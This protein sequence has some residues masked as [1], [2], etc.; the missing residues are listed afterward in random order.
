MLFD[1]RLPRFPLT[2]VSDYRLLAKKRLPHQIFEFLDGGAFDEVTKRLNS[3]DFQRIL[4]RKRVLRDVSHI[5][6]KTE[7]LGHK[8]DFPVI[9]APV[10]FAGLFA[11]RGEVQAARAAYKANIPFSLSSVGICSMEEVSKAS[12]NPFW[13]ELKI[14]KDRK[15]S[16]ENLELAKNL[17]CSVLFLTVDLPIVGARYRYDR[18]R[19]VS[20]LANFW[21]I[22]SHFSWWSDIYLRGGPITIGNLPKNSPPISGLPKIRKWISTHMDQIAWKDIDWVRK[23]WPGKIVIKGILDP[24]DARMAENIG[25]D[26]IVVSNHGARHLDSTSSTIAA[27]PAIVEA[28]NN[29]EILIDGGIT[30]GLDVIKALALGAK[31]CMVGKAWA[32]GLAARGEQGVSEVLTILRNELRMAMSHLG[33]SSIAEIDHELISRKNQD[34]K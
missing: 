7:V 12:S 27:L 17:G 14:F 25:A 31:A 19:K 2:S 4:L 6:L 16:L 10:G 23:H 34:N 13:L 9:L 8:L 24:E 28:V 32:F 15:Y 1:Q 29:L 26:G 30:S 22:F 33:I 20:R 11:R 3:E 21:E 18:S 5:D